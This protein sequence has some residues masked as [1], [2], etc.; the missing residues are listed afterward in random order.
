MRH[1]T[2]QADKLLKELL[3]LLRTLPP[4]T[5]QAHPGIP[6]V[7]ASFEP[8]V[9]ELRKIIS[10]VCSYD[11]DLE[12]L[13]ASMNKW[14]QQLLITGVHVLP[15]HGFEMLQYPLLQTYKHVTH[16]R[17]VN[18]IEEHGPL[19][20]YSS[21]VK[22]A[23]HKIAKR[24]LKV[25][26]T[27]GGGGGRRVRRMGFLSWTLQCSRYLAQRSACV[28]ADGFDQAG[29]QL[30]DELETYSPECD[31]AMFDGDSDGW[32]SLCES[33]LEDLELEAAELE[34]VGAAA[35]TSRTRGRSRCTFETV[36]ALTL[37]LGC[38][39]AADVC[40]CKLVLA[41]KTCC[42]GD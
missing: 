24:M 6:A 23:M 11:P 19:V 36:R 21:W 31:A 26:C 30:A 9:E 38:R 32:S 33:E 35:Q 17:I 18:I 25:N 15:L 37:A 3:A 4:V 42:L 1:C 20:Q 12:Q 10:Q 34:L 13:R 8:M 22:E 28:R 7:V 2:L 14:W 16:T 40:V 41:H 29:L 27:C 5:E 39:V